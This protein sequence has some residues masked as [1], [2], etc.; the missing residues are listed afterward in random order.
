MNKEEI[1]KRAQNERT[2]RPDEMEMDILLKSNRVGLMVGLV[3][4][5][6]LMV[7]KMYFD[8]AYMD[9]YAVFCSIFCGQYLYKWFHLKKKSMLL[10]GVIWGTSALLLFVLYLMKFL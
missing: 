2:N 5:L 6:M 4:C 10:C 7:I 3:I 9:V 8:Q 1:L